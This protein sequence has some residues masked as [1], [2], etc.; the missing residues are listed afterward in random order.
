MVIFKRKRMVPELADGAPPGSLV[1][2]SDTGYTNADLFVTW[3]QHFIAAVTPSK[4][5]RVLLVL[6]GHTTH[7]RDL[8]AIEMARENGVII[9]QLPGH[10]THRLQ[11]L[12]VAVFKPFQVHYDQSVEKWL[13]E[14]PG[15]TIGQFQVARLTGEGY[16]KAA[17]VANAISGFKKCGIWPVD[18]NVFTMLILKAEKTKSTSGKQ[19]R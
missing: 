12:D 4:E 1:E 10:T 15:R 9:L 6:D 17:C 8:A 5:D 19:G 13:R 11:P 14:H 18:R 2:I 7:S 16:G 3:L